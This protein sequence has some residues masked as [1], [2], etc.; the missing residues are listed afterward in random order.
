MAEGSKTFI[1]HTDK[2]VNITLFVRDGDSPQDKGG[3]ELV[4]VP[5]HGGHVTMIY[6]GDPGSLGYVYL[7]GLLVEWQ[8]GPDMVGVSRKVAQRGDAWD[9]VL[10]TNDTVSISALTSGTFMASGSNTQ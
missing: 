6:S 10:N 8:E 3:T 9:N 7:N 1:N 4:S 2:D 5:K